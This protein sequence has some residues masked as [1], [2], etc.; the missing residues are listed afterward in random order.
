MPWATP[1]VCESVYK[2][3]KP[4][5]RFRAE[6]EARHFVQNFGQHFYIAKASWPKIRDDSV[7]MKKFDLLR[8]PHPLGANR[9]SERVAF[10][11]EPGARE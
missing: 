11:R 2:E 9:R 1:K 7:G 3:P 5:H 4:S 8:V 10:S 6:K